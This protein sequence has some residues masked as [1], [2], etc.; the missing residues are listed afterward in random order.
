MQRQ[1]HECGDTNQHGCVGT[2]YKH[3]CGAKAKIARQGV[4]G[5]G[6]GEVGR[7]QNR[8]GLVCL[9]QG[10]GL[11]FWGQLEASEEQEAGE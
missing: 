10:V 8:K 5:K 6:T 1:E 11:F 4:E 7:T 9:L 2:I 3:L